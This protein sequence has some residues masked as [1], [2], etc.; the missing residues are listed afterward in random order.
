[1]C[2]WQ[3]AR[4]TQRRHKLVHRRRAPRQGLTLV[5]YTRPPAAS[6]APPAASPPPPTP[7][8]LT[9]AADRRRHRR[10]APSTAAATA[11]ER[12]RR[13]AHVPQEVGVAQRP[14]PGGAQRVGVRARC[15]AARRRREGS[16]T[17]PLLSST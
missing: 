8:P 3:G 5:H 9:A 10:A 14:E 2:G 4:R 17:R 16:Y 12:R 1:V 11:A 15:R 7:P 13:V 6:P